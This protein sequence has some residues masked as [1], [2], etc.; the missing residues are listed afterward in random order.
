MQQAVSLPGPNQRLLIVGRTGSGKT[1]AGGFHLSQS[2]FDLKPWT[3][4]DFK[5][6]EML[7]AIQHTAYLSPNDMPPEKPGIYMLRMRVDQQ[8]ELEE[9]LWKVYNRGNHGLF[10]DEGYMIGQGKQFSP[11]FRGI[12]T[13]GRSKNIPV[14]INS[15]RPVWLDVFT[16]SEANK[17]Q[18]FHL[19]GEDDR[20]AMSKFIPSDK[21]DLEKRLAPYHSVYYDIDIDEAAELGPVPPPEVS[22]ALIN[23]RL[24]AMKENQGTDVL[25]DPTTNKP[26]RI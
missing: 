11:A 1:V 7:N 12:L 18:V 4:I 6:D 13:Q 22:L 2:D 14:I 5:G 21:A 24:R 17:M 10:A 3:I 16:K 9:Y 20:K 23:E 25:S 19:N 15:Q 26:K 8:D